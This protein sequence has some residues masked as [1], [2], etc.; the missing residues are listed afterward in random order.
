MYAKGLSF[1]ITERATLSPSGSH[2][3]GETKKRKRIAVF[4]KLWKSRKSTLIVDEK[5][6]FISYAGLRQY[7]QNVGF[8]GNE[9]ISFVI[10]G[11]NRRKGSIPN[12]KH[13]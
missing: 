10:T 3:T 7:A 9:V 5:S 12:I 1:I 13:L 2:I 11:A 8:K 6:P 4:E